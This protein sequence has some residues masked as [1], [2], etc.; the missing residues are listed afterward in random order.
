MQDDLRKRGPL[1]AIKLYDRLL[2]KYPSHEHNDR[3]LYQKARA[4]D[5]LGRTTEAMQV[6]E[7]LIAAYPDS[8]HLDELLFRRG[9]HFFAR[10]KFREAEGSYERD[11]RDGPASEFY[12]LGLYKLGWALYKQDFYDEALHRYVALLDYKVS[13]GYD[14]D[15][16]HEEGDERRIAD[17]FDIISLSFSNLGGPQIAQEYFTANGKRGYEDRVYRNL[18]EYYLRKL[19]YH[20]AAKSYDTF[21]AQ[22]PLHRRSPHFSMRVI[23][24][25][26]TGR[27]PQLV[28]DSKKAFASTYGLNAEYWRH[29]DVNESPEVLSYL[30]GNLKDLANHYHAQYQAPQPRTDSQRQAR[31]LHRGDALVSRIHQLVPRGRG[32][33]GINYQLADLQLE[34]QDFAAAANEYQR[35]AYEYPRARA[36]IRRRLR[37]DLCP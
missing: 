9:E 12:E 37:R 32:T 29:F 31:Q 25:Y 6:M 14:F 23:E 22:Y 2:A 20:D 21:V 10:K 16:Q 8:R 27:F 36:C 35:T 15:A 19:R 3:V 1:E 5:E 33:P 7:Q 11:H 26:E 24:I 28:L 17:T 13:V 30:K 4:Y 18:G 34:H